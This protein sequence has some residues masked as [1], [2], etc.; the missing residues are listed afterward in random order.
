MNRYARHADRNDSLD[1]TLSESPDAAESTVLAAIRTWLR[2]HC[3]G[4]HGQ[5]NW[6]L[7]LRHAGMRRDGIERFDI[8]MRALMTVSMRPLDMRCRCASEL[9]KDEASLL[10]AIALLQ[11]TRSQ[12]AVS[13]MGEWLPQ[14]AVSG[15][16]KIIRWLAIDL[17]EA[18]LEIRVRHRDVSYM[19]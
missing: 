19:H 11:L 18:G 5:S 8:M 2:P 17:L 3:G 13:L 16:V 14:P 10:Q 9:A 6:Q 1:E 15:L 4:A 7:T 12:A